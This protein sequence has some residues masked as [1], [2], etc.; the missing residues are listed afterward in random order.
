MAEKDDPTDVAKTGIEALMAG[1][2]P[3]I[4]IRA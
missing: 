3:V 4:N 2:D 1:E